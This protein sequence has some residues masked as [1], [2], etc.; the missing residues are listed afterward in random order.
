MIELRN[1]TLGYSQRTLIKDATTR[2][3]RGTMV[4]L[5][6]RNGTGKSTL[7]RTIARLMDAQQGEIA[8]NGT[9]LAD[10]SQ[11]ELARLVAFVTTER[12][13]V[14]ALT[15]YDLVAIG[16]SPYTGWMGRL[17]DADRAAIERAMDIA[18][19][20]HMAE[21]RVSTMSDGE[22]QRV[23]IARA[24]AQDTPIILLDE[25]TAFLDLP[26]RYELCTLLSRLA[27]EEERCV[28][29]STHELDIALSLADSIAL[30]DSPRLVHLP[31]AEMITSGNI[32]RL[33]DSEY[34]SFDAEN[35]SIRL[36]R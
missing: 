30:V 10:M 7:L 36:R 9:P 14:E 5:L 29:F 15:A 8:I 20:R 35:Q 24:L 32:E 19:V 26:N 3:E 28:I 34:V 33:F 27:H 4:A 2:F 11:A 31:T 23:M 18:G 22:C 16:R 1:I 17:T 12:I 13:D 21:R 25:P 6:G